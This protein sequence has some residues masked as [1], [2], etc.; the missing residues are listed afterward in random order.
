VFEGGKHSVT[1]YKEITQYPKN[2]LL[3]VSPLT[4]RT[5]QIRVH[6]DSIGYGIV[7]DELYGKS[8]RNLERQFLHAKK[9]GFL[10][11]FSNKYTEFECPL[12]QDLATF[13]EDL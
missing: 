7:G 2:S 1:K 9:I 3:E 8:N 4:G 6:L 12:P 10:M 13:L 5:H 11:P